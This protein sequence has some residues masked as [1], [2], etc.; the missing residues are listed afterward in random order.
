MFLATRI[1]M[2]G[3]QRSFYRPEQERG[4]ARAHA[5]FPRHRFYEVAFPPANLYYRNH[6]SPLHLQYSKFCGLGSVSPDYPYLALGD[7][8]A[9]RWADIMHYTRTGE[10]IHAGALP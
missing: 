4:K 2:S 8:G 3:V 9:K 10:V 7:G 1:R 5:C 6:G